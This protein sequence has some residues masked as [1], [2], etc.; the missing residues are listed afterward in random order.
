MGV[1]AVLVP[2]D[3]VEVVMRVD[4]MGYV[5]GRET[6][7]PELRRNGLV[8]GLERLL[9]WE[10]LVDVVQVIASIEEE[11]SF[12]MVDQHAV[13]READLAAGPGVPVQVVAVNHQ[14]PTI[15]QVHAHF[16]CHCPSRASHR[17]RTTIR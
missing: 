2:A 7:G 13:A 16:G 14:C 17:V 8:G 15:E 10:D 4:D 5:V 9:E 11:L 1:A 6:D 12:G 3:V